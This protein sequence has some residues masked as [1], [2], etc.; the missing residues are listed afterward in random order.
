MYTHSFVRRSVR[1]ITTLIFAL[2]LLI[3]SVK[4]HP[5]NTIIYLYSFAA[6]SL[7]QIPSVNPHTDNLHDVGLMSGLSSFHDHVGSSG[8]LGSSRSISYNLVARETKWAKTSGI[9]KLWKSGQPQQALALLLVGVTRGWR[10]LLFYSTT[11][12]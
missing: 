12:W 9:G 3:Y 7:S 11:C 8:W 10:D 4:A 1:T 6:W 2:L 5:S